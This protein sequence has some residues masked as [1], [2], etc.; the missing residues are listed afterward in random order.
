MLVTQVGRLR[1]ALA[2]V[3]LAAGLA[4]KAEA[5]DRDLRVLFVGNSLTYQ[6]DL[7][8]I[9]QALIDSAGLGPSTMA[10]V[11]FPNFGLEDH[12]VDGTARTAISSQRWSIVALQQGPSATE[13]RPSLLEFT[14]RFAPLITGAG[15]RP[16]L[17]MVWPSRARAFDFDGVSES[18]RM[19]ADLVGGL[20]FPVGDAWRAAWRMDS[21]LALYGPDGFHPSP[22]GSYLAALVMFEQITGRSPV[23]LPPAL[24]VDAPASAPAPA[25][26]RIDLPPETAALLQR[27]AAEA[28]AAVE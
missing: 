27:A 4:N 16:A 2:V 25:P 18:Y 10:R 5:Q 14:E 21:T 24:D 12:W 22:S 28:N 6:N 19:A 7:P 17:Y 13:G 23:G 11:A 15:A 1:I 20:L 8:S 3:L 9:L 26:V